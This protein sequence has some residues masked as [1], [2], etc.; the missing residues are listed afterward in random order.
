MPINYAKLRANLNLA[1]CRALLLMKQKMEM[2]KRARQEIVK[3]VSKQCYERASLLVEH[4]IL[5]QN[6][7]EAMEIVKLY[8]DFLLTQFTLI[9]QMNITT[10]DS[11]ESHLVAIV[12][13]LWA[14]QHFKIEVPELVIVSKQFK[15]KFSKSFVEAASK[16]VSGTVNNKLIEKLSSQ[17]LPQTLVQKYINEVATVLKVENKPKQNALTLQ[18][19]EFPESI[20]LTT[21]TRKMSSPPQRPPRK[22]KSLA[23]ATI[24]DHIENNNAL[25]GLTRSVEA[26]NYPNPP[27]DSPSASSSTIDNSSID[28]ND[29]QR[30]FEKLKDKK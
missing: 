27:K 23:P 24:E 16:N 10:I 14:T 12:S 18:I 2:N 25:V 6:R 19:A 9:E 5:E 11:Y 29:I 17:I 22:S 28:F 13:L 3:L 7:F 1:K 8:C 4:I 20:K 21:V 15:A 30:R 26:I